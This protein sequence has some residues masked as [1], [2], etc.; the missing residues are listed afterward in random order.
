MHLTDVR[1]G[2]MSGG[3]LVPGRRIDRRL[4]NHSSGAMVHANNT[5]H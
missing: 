3:T 5:R 1:A 2:H 4:C